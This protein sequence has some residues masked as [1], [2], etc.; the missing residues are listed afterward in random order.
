[1]AKAA[2]KIAEFYLALLSND[3]SDKR[4]GAILGNRNTGRPIPPRVSY[5]VYAGDPVRCVINRR[6]EDDSPGRDPVF[7][8]TEIGLV[9]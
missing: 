6:V 7:S 2:R 4:Y 9:T 1:V 3:I 5:V 8:G